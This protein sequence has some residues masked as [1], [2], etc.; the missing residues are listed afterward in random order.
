MLT[1]TLTG[2]VVLMDN[3]PFSSI[4]N[5]DKNDRWID[6]II[7]GNNLRLN[8]VGQT[9]TI[10]IH[11][12]APDVPVS[13]PLYKGTL[14]DGNVIDLDLGDLG[15]P[16]NSVTSEEDAPRVAEQV[17]AS[18]GGIPSDALLV[19]VNTSYAKRINDDTGEILEKWPVST[20]VAYHRT[21]KGMPIVGDG[22]K[23]LI[24]LGENGEPL[25]IVK[26]W[27]TLEYTGSNVSIISPQQA[28][29]KLQN[30]ESMNHPL[31]DQKI[32]ITNI[33]L[34][35]YEKSRSDP[36]IFLEPVWIFSGTTTSRDRVS[37]YVYA[38]QFANFTATSTSGKV[39]LTVTFTDTSEA[40][41]TKWLWN[42][43]DSTNTTEQNP[44]HTYTSI[45]TYNVTLRAWNDL[46][47]DT[48]EKAGYITVRNPAPPIA[49]FTA[50]PTSGKAPLTVQFNDTSSN[51]PTGWHWE[52]G[53]MTNST[54]QNPVHVYNIPGVYNVSLNAI[55]EDG[56]AIKTWP[57]YITVSK[58]DTPADLI[59]QLILYIN[60][61][62]KVP[63]IF[64]LM[65]TGQLKEVKRFLIGNNPSD[66]VLLMKY[67]KLSVGIFKGSV[68]TSD[69]AAT[70]QIS[71]D[72]IIRA[73]NLPVNQ[74]AI[75][76]TKSLSVDVKNLNLP[77]SVERP[78]TLELDGTIFTLECAKDQAAISHLNLFISSVKAQDGKKI[79]HDKAVQMIA[80]A[81][82]I[83]KTIKP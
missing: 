39:P 81:Q 64:K 38:W 35:V 30:G 45:G 76:Q 40:S 53:D 1:A 24:D 5:A 49:N 41:P 48:M 22:D 67:F 74:A 54:V 47:S 80:K 17:M 52:F 21:L 73:I 82:G 72:A 16:K 2:F 19:L 59:D 11:A 28:I 75:D 27:R 25:W 33:S 44:S 8:I 15:S 58:P 71:A 63:K 60:N 46:G 29:E 4:H 32:I 23:I 36:Q 79:P 31:T 56:S 57:D 3:S 78:L 66:A 10:T 34:G 77:A 65:W 61:Q 6:G 51:T 12:L 68:I 9:G 13:F 43:G 37:F 50:A 42:F 20:T 7:T 26:I 83:I 18:Y 62:N 69:Q 14:S 55:N 70:M